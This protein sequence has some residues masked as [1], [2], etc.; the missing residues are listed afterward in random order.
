MEGHVRVPVEPT[1]EMEYAFHNGQT[2]T[3]Q[4]F[5]ERYRNML[6]A[7]PDAKRA[8]ELQAAPRNGRPNQ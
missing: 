4:R 7:R 2:S 3:H 5:R 6:S 1:E 8:E